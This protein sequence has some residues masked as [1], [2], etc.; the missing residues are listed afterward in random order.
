[1]F[2][3]RNAIPGRLVLYLLLSRRIPMPEWVADR[4]RRSKVGLVPR[5]VP[6]EPFVRSR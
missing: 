2:G 6:K 1:M 3:L 5:Q 4:E